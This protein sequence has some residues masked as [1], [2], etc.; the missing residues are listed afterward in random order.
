MK[1]QVFDY[2]DRGNN[3]ERR[4]SVLNSKTV[5]GFNNQMIY[6]RCLSNS[7]VFVLHKRMLFD[8]FKNV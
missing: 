5:D 4:C 8:I 6:K 7:A 3:R 1:L 2:S